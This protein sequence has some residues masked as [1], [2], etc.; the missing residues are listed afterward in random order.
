MKRLLSISLLAVACAA[1]VSPDPAHAGKSKDKH[2]KK[3]KKGKKG[4]GKRGKGKRGRDRHDDDDDGGHDDDDDG[5]DGGGSRTTVSGAG[6]RGVASFGGKVVNGPR[7]TRGVFILDIHPLAP[8]GTTLSV[9]CRF[10]RFENFAIR[11]TRVTFRGHGG[12]RTLRTDGTI[13][14][15]ENTNDFEIADN[16]RP[17]RDQIDID[18][19]GDTGVGVP[20][21]ALEFGDLV[22][23]TIETSS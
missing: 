20:G 2:G 15:T 9:A 6:Q 14:F 16:P 10:K 12:C 4:K 17:T 19:V 1:L 23:E 3:G 21:G 5:G 11:G 18:F 13:V 7:G 22:I 8:A